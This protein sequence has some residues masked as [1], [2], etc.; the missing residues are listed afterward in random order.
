MF[1]Q[2]FGQGDYFAL[3]SVEGGLWREVCTWFADFR[4][5]STVDSVMRAAEQS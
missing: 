3:F 1:F 2:G 5:V 4:G